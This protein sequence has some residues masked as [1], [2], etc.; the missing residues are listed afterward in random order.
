M[1]DSMPARLAGTR[2]QPGHRHWWRRSREFASRLSCRCCQD[3]DGG[4]AG[5]GDGGSTVGDDPDTVGVGVGSGPVGAAD[6]CVGVTS[7]GV[8][9]GDDEELVGVGV[10]VLVLAATGQVAAFVFV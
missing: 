3:R 7:A 1:S 2:W 9:S 10:G 8:G 6:A 4:S 5:L